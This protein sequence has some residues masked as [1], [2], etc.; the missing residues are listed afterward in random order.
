MLWKL[1]DSIALQQALSLNEKFNQSDAFGI[2]TLLL[3]YAQE[4]SPLEAFWIV[5]SDSNAWKLLQSIKSALGIVLIHHV[6]LTTN[7]QIT[8]TDKQA[9]QLLQDPIFQR[10]RNHAKDLSAT[11]NLSP[12]DIAL[13]TNQ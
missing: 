7:P 2:V 6:W 12:E 9:Q 5:S 4:P 13:V 10:L 8:I 11:S 1:S 3:Q